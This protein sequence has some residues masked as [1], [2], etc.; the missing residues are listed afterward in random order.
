MNLMV[1]LLVEYRLDSLLFAALA[2]GGMVAVDLWLRRV[3]RAAGVRPAA[4]VALGS[5][6]LGAAV[7]AEHNG[8]RA[9][10]RHRTT[11]ESFASTYAH[12]LERM[13][14][15]RLSWDLAPDDPAYL[16]M[17]DIQT[18]WLRGN[19]LVSD[20]YTFR[21]KADGTVA[22]LVDSETDYD[23]NGRY[24]GE[25]E[26]RTP[27]G[28]VYPEADENMAV[29]LDGTAAFDGQPFTDRWG[30][31]VSAYVP[32]YDEGGC[33]EG[34]LGVDYDATSWSAMILSQRGVV[35]GAAAVLVVILLAS[36]A[37]GTALRAEVERRRG[38]ERA[39]VASEERARLIVENA[40]DAVV[41]LDAAGR[42]TGWNPKAE[43]IFGW[44]AAEAVGRP[45][46][47][48]ILPEHA[49][50]EHYRR[51]A[52]YAV[53]GDAVPRNTRV[54]TVAVRRGGG[55]FAV[56]LSITRLPVSGGAGAFGAFI[57]DISER[58]AAEQAL[59]Q[60]EERFRVAA[61]CAGDSIYEWH[62][63]GGRLDW[64]G[65]SERHVGKLLP[66]ID[67]WEKAIHPEDRPRVMESLE[68]HVKTGTPF[69]EQYRIVDADGAVRHVTDRGAVLPDAVGR[70]R[71]MVGAMSDVT[72]QQQAQ[73]L[74]A[75]KAALKKAVASMEQ[76][77]GVV[78]HELRTPLAGVRA[79]SEFLLDGTAR[80]TG[81]FDHFL[82]GMNQEVVRMAETVNNLLEAAR[83]NSGRANWNWS[84]F[85]VA[86]VCREAVER[87]RPLVDG[88]AVTLSC[89]A[90]AGLP[91][92][93]GDA[94]AVARLVLNL[95]GN[96]AKH[97]KAGRIAV[98]ARG[99]EERGRR[100]VEVAVEDTG[101]GIAPE[102]LGRLGEAFALNAGIVGEKYVKG[103]GL[104][105]AICAGIAAAH[106]GRMRFESR[107]GD[108]TR[109]T[110]R[111]RADLPGAVAGAGGAGAHAAG[112]AEI[113]SETRAD[114]AAV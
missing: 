44:P 32:L 106:G 53:A 18:R 66:T 49:R 103:T 48:T 68:R 39:L 88:G 108:G 41:T 94:E 71:L 40:L 31:W 58:Q 34:A 21:R 62:L 57:R 54:E 63:D 23:H 76:V 3:R 75:E 20:I 109:A 82:R 107:V 64:F 16:A 29:A 89:E 55:E 5:L 6:L 96:A 101:E 70:A 19:P 9:R 51:L 43:A 110:V 45:L 90:S 47:E 84:T 17:I 67:A 12:A 73:A 97:T 11:L 105:L 113:P 14:H 46:A 77:L 52:E 81:E 1:H 93:S 65:D 28:E 78:A 15:A 114:A 102:I 100:W 2:A 80:E 7:V 111:L 87:V 60:S 59:R 104:G 37:S 72:Q 10:D 83:I 112:P 56:E 91:E 27:V 42:I 8:A 61:Q 50:E 79:M 13:G 95:L 24:E 98:S 99:F 26:G 38:V 22:F 4:W 33:V 74:E 92:M 25:R 30:T 86:E 85:D 35:L 69:R 36:T